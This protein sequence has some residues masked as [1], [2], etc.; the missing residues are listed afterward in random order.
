MSVPFVHYGLSLRKA[1]MQTSFDVIGDIH[2]ELPTLKELG[3]ALGY[4]VRRDWRHPRERI[5]VFLGDLVDRGKHSLEVAELVKNLVTDRRAFCI[6]GNH[7]YNLAA[8][9]LGVPGYEKPKK[10]NAATIKEIEDNRGRW[11]PVLEWFRDLPIG[12]EL[13]GLRIIHACWHKKSLDKIGPF[14]GVE[15]RPEPE[16]KTSVFDLMNSHI[17]LRSPFT[18]AGLVQGLPGDTAD[19]SAVIPHEDL[20]KGFEMDTDQPFT[21]N[22]GKVRTRVRCAWWNNGMHLVLNDKPQVFG[23]YWNC[24]PIHGDMA[25]PHPTGTPRLREWG[26]RIAERCPPSGRIQMQGNMVCV[27]FQGITLASD[28]ACIGALRWPEREI[29]WE[30]APKTAEENEDSE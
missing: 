1:E 10:S 25:P 26:R 12:V 6:M 18:R 29:V 23:H 8:W 7:E 13:P 15:L 11:Q 30:S 9:D 24:P 4:D 17:V 5:L 22:D 21:D 20:M 19:H 2:G 14:L 16:E 28:R 27:D 3:N